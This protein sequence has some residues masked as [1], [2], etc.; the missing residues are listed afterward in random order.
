MIDLPAI[1]IKLSGAELEDFKADAAREIA[2]Q[3]AEIDRL[4]AEI[5]AKRAARSRKRKAKP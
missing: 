3:K 4:N 2:R 1:V 5:K